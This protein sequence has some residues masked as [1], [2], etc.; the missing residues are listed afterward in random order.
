MG[1]VRR[2]DD[3]PASKWEI[4][5]R[6][7]DGRQRTKGGFGR[8]TDAARALAA[9]EADIQRGVD[10]GDPRRGREPFND[11]AAFWLESAKR[12]LKAKTF[13]GYEGVVSRHLVPEFGKTPIAWIDHERVQRFINDLSHRYAGG[14]VRKVHTVLRLVMGSAVKR[15]LIRANP[16][17][18]VELPSMDRTEM[19]FLSAEQV[20]ALAAATP[21]HYR[22]MIRFAA[23]TGLRAGEL[24]A[25]RVADLNL[26]NGPVYVTRSLAD[27]GGTL[28]EGTTKTGRNRRVGI[29]ADLLPE[30]REHLARIDRVHPTGTTPEGLVFPGDRG[31][32]LR[33]RNFMR[34]HFHDAVKKALPAEY[35]GL[36]FHDLRH[37]CAALLIAAGANPKD[38]ADR[39]GH[40]SITVTVDVYGHRFESHDTALTE[41]LN[42]TLRSTKRVAAA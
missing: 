14:T 29:P 27:V 38:I 15:G 31:G 24:C 22:A 35:H 28:I 13:E 40:S 30:L 17:I 33:H 37:T 8:K 12:Q 42:E 39:L 32:Y 41:R 25:L 34:R 16:C 23:Y 1:S 5:Y 4:R 18:D 10:N 2:R 19:L 21:L 6:D 7:A 9:K 26:P 11:V 3:R 20:E 36:R